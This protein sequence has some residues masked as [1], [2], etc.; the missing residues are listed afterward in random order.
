MRSSTASM[1]LMP[2]EVVELFQQ[3][4]CE[5]RDD[6]HGYAHRREAACDAALSVSVQRC[7]AEGTSALGPGRGCTPC[8]STRPVGD[9]CGRN[10]PNF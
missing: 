6:A 1:S 4:A 7:A 5:M 8:A 10:F 9:V 3:V 2:S